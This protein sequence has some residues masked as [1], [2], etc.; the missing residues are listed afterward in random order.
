MACDAGRYNSVSKLLPE[1]SASTCWLACFQSLWSVCQYY[2][3]S[4]SNN[5]YLVC[6]TMSWKSSNYLA[7]CAYLSGLLSRLTDSIVQPS[8]VGWEVYGFSCKLTGHCEALTVLAGQ[9]GGLVWGGWCSV[10]HRPRNAVWSLP[11]G[12]TAL[13][14]ALPSK[15]PR[16]SRSV[17]YQPA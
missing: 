1:V 6:A 5:S 7:Q 8:Q 16:Y 14:N 10:C 11:Q 2:A 9:A 17:P 15:A 13:N 3:P 12:P 4:I